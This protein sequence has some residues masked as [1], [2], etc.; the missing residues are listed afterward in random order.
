MHT[1]SGRSRHARSR[2]RRNRSIADRPRV[3]RLDG[4]TSAPT[5]SAR[6]II[7]TALDKVP[8]LDPHTINDLI[9][10]CG[11][12]GGEQGFNLGARARGE[13]RPRRRR[14]YDDHPLLLVQP[15]VHPH[16]L[17]RDQGRRGRRLRQR[18]RRDGQPLH[19]GQQ[20]LAARHP[21]SRVRRRPGALGQGGRRRL[22]LVRPPRVG[23]HP[24]RLH[25]DGPDRRERRR[26]QGHLPRGAGRVRR[27]LAEPRREGDRQRVLGAR[28]HRG[29][30][31]ERRG[32][33]Q[34]RRPAA[35]A[36]HWK[37]SR[38]SSRSSG[39]TARSP[40]A[41]AARS[42]TVSPRSS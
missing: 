32:R 34:G 8:Q 9:V 28:D 7:Q 3:Q 26:A 35:R 41:T 27:P 22:S 40:P 18:R 14:R 25:R 39:P 5:T 31:A 11:L 21:G 1:S 20:R 37:A 10:G 2:H 38:R 12:P 33:R 42:T 24:R 15:A 17:P 23:Q 4:A 19:Q 30:L 16:G 29:H 13:A 6:P 36:S